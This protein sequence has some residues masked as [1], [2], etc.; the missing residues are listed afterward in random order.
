MSWR[1]IVQKVYGLLEHEE[2]FLNSV[3]ESH[4]EYVHAEILQFDKSFSIF[5]D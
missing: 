4:L 3:Q 2:L 1:E 5:S